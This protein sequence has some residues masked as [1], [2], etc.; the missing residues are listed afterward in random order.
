MRR[1]VG[2]IV[3][4]SL[5]GCGSGQEKAEMVT[6]E[7]RLAEIVSGE[8]LTEMSIP[9]SFEKFYLHDEV[10]VSNADIAWAMPGSWQ[11]RPVVELTL[12]ETGREK[13]AQLTA[14][15]VG[16]RMGIVVDGKLVIVPMIQA[17][18]LDGKAVIDGNFSEQETNRIAAGIISK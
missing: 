9:G 7:F 17:P 5:L 18:M 13:F 4:L 3:L 14:D 1:I 6:V 2:L 11:G 15:N 16:K 12:T 8:G 10:L